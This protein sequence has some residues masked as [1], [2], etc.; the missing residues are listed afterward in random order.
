MRHR[1]FKYF[2]ADF[3]T[4]VYDSQDRTD[5]WAVG[6]CEL[7]TENSYVLHSIDDLLHYCLKQCDNICLYF[8]N[9]KF[10]GEFI[11]SYLINELHL[12]QALMKTPDIKGNMNYKFIETK[13]MPN[14]SFKYSISHKGMWYTIVIKY[15]GRIIEIRDSLKLLPYSV[16]KLGKDFKTKHQKLEMEYKGY[17]FPGCAITEDE[18][19]YIKNDVMVPKE[20]LEIMFDMGHKKL[21][22][23]SCC[24]EEYKAIFKKGKFCAYDY[25]EIFP[26]QYELPDKSG[27]YDSIGRYIVKS[28]KGALCMLV[29][30]KE[31]KVFYNGYTFDVNSLYPYVMHSDSGNYYP[32]GNPKYWRGNYIPQE[33]TEN[34]HYFFVRVRTR[35]YLKEGKLPFIQIKGNH[36]YPA[37]KQLETSDVYDKKTEKYYRQYKDK[38]GNV[39]EAFVELTLTMSDYELIQEIYNLEDFEIIDGYWYFTMIGL[40][41]E[42]IDKY[43]KIK[44]ESTGGIKGIAKLLSNN[45]YGKEAASDDSSF[46]VIYTHEDGSLGFIT[47]IEK[48]KEPGYIPIGSAITSY[49]RCYTYRVMQANYYG[50]DKPGSIYCDTD[51]V[52]LDVPLEKIK[53]IT[54]DAL[55]YG[56]WKCESSWDYAIF[57]RQKTYIEHVIEENHNPC[58][59]YYNIKCA[60]MPEQ[61]K[62]LLIES[63]TNYSTYEDYKKKHEKE[64]LE[65]EAFLY[66]LKT[67]EK[68][69][70][71]ITDFK[72][73][74]KI[75]GKLF[76]KHIPGGVLL[77]EGYYTMR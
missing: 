59:P 72:L 76:P 46:K 17:R 50:A 5:V 65:R 70:R 48:D 61:C 14:N 8:H 36:L 13:N 39:M 9:L 10:D 64:N 24:L 2:M 20:A 7:Y 6:I 30:G 1:S 57:V 23:G 15:K 3:E 25:E 43:K 22:I 38:D 56:M 58:T 49:A 74:L 28:Y 71:D 55:V 34:H 66:D 42:Y 29:K 63:I 40:F 32:V 27:E 47:Q 45:L 51:S 35:F 11:I 60:G 53:G 44:M 4:T 31:N 62:K 73:G 18:K 69:H 54:E 16:K 75:P 52:H 68:I 33:A 41:D 12:Q 21:T 26:N 77:E 37:T 19:A 67:K